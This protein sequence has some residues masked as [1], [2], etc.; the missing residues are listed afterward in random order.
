M[1]CELARGHDIMV[2]VEEGSIGGFGSHVLELLVVPIRKGGYVHG[3]RRVG[4]D[5]GNSE[6]FFSLIF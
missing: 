3:Q 1:I 5:M 4:D 6:E 2:T